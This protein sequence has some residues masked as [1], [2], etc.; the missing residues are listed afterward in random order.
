[1]GNTL[2]I[3][4]RILSETDNNGKTLL[5]LFRN[6]PKDTV[7][8]IYFYGNEPEVPG[9]RYFQ[10]C[11]KDIIKG[12]LGK[13]Y[14]GRAV[15]AIQKKDIDVEKQNT[16][17]LRKYNIKRSPA[18]I[19]L[20]ELLWKHSWNSLQLQKWLD[21]IQPEKV[22]FLAGDCVYAYD[23]CKW[24]CNRYKCRLFTYITDDY[25]LSRSK[26]TFFEKKHR[27]SVRKVLKE[28]AKSSDIFFTICN[29][30][31]EEYA[32]LFGVDSEI[33]INQCGFLY[34]EVLS[35]ESDKK[36]EIVF[37]YAGSLYY[38]RD[39]V[40]LELARTL[41]R[42]N[43]KLKQ[44]QKKS[45]LRIYSNAKPCEEL[46]EEME[47]IGT[48]S[49]DGVLQQEE[50]KTQLNLCNVPVFVESFNE[51]QMEKTRL[52]FSTKVP[53]YLSLKKPILAIGPAGIGS[54]DCLEEVSFCVNQMSQMDDVVME[55]L[56]NTEKRRLLSKMAYEKC[57]ELMNQP[58][59]DAYM[60]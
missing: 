31:R 18:L 47:R 55:L 36:D 12:K 38:G 35:V 23:I 4:N 34:D 51:E 54:M 43:E 29:R 40:L 59:L 46:L 28:C 53:E 41:K 17:L 9:Y 45:R 1:M 50:L 48:V 26:E 58:S 14:R 27:T 5:N 11:D 16:T 25:V 60:R 37:V 57:V 8:Q 19:C 49:F 3:S 2:I 30:M 21:E 15:E 33:L 10:L 6:I 44:G 24:I 42:I 39:E 13:K 7:A 56:T 32:S 52:S 22:F 20:R